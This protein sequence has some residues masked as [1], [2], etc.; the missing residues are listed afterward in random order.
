MNPTV[1]LIL[2]GI[3]V[4]I[5]IAIIAW[6]LFKAG[7]KPKELTVKAGPVEAK[8]ERDTGAAPPPATAHPPRAE[9]RQQASDGGQIDNSNITLPADSGAKASQKAEGTGSSISN[10]D[11]KIE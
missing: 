1:A 5:I 8:M 11:I 6:L 10:S 9:A 3:A 2:G 4:V 7:F